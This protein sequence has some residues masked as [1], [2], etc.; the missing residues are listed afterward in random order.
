[1]SVQIDIDQILDDVVT[2]ISNNSVGLKLA[3]KFLDSTQMTSANFPLCDVRPRQLVP[4][5]L[6]TGVYYF[7]LTVDLEIVALDLSSPALALK[8]VLDKLKL[9]Q[10]ILVRKPYF[11]AAWDS[12]ILGPVDFQAG[13]DAKTGAGITAALAQVYI[14]AY[15]Q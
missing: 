15:A 4:E 6:A 1:M 2:L 14:S 5:P 10:E 12:V 13:Q 9:V 11:G 7:R 8:I 3:A